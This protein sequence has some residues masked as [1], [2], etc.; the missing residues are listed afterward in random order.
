MTS[1]A[2]SFSGSGALGSISPRSF[3]TERSKNRNS[4][5]PRPSRGKASPQFSGCLIARPTPDPHF[6]AGLRFAS[7]RVE[8]SPSTSSRRASQSS[9]VT[10]PLTSSAPA[11]PPDV[12]LPG[13]PNGAMTEGANVREHQSSS[14]IQ[15]AASDLAQNWAIDEHVRPDDA[16]RDATDSLSRSPMSKDSNPRT[17]RVNSRVVRRS[18]EPNRIEPEAINCPR[19]RDSHLH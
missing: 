1:A 8:T 19:D 15:G 16:I 2:N 3:S 13:T 5:V 17:T 11:P 14:G 10:A 18:T 7:P 4:H 9:F 12:A 6:A